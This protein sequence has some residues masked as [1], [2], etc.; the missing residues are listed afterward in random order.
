MTETRAER[1][2]DDESTRRLAQH[3]F[4]RPLV[5]E[6]GAGTGKT[7]LL[8]ARVVAWCVGPGWDRHAAGDPGLRAVARRVIER[9]VAITFTEA[10]AAEMAR[11]ISDAF[12]ALSRGEKLE[13]FLPEIEGEPEDAATRERAAALADEKIVRALEGKKIR[14]VIVV[15]GRLVNIVAT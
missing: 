11:R 5:V 6:A 1:I 15:K 3:E 2:A 8:V 7:T 14:K 13:G 10:A 4:E 9:V 12:G